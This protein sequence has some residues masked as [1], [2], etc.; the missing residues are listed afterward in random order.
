VIVK[1]LAHIVFYAVCGIVLLAA[2][3]LI[4]RQKTESEASARPVAAL[5]I[6]PESSGGAS[7]AQASR[8]QR[9]SAVNR[10]SA[11][12]NELILT[13][14]NM[15]LDEDEGDEQILTV[16]KTDRQGGF[17][18]IVV[19]DYV[20]QRRSWIRSWE[21]DTLCTK[22]STF[23]IQLKDLIGDHDN[24]IVCT[25]MA[26]SGMQTVN[27]FRR[28]PGSGLAFESIL[29][30]SAESI[31]IGETERNESYQLGQ[32]SGESWP[33]FAYRSNPGS[34]NVLDQIKERYSWN[35]KTKTY[36][37]TGEERITGA[38]ME[39][40]AVGRILT[41]SSAD[42]EEFLMG[43]WYESTNGPSGPLS[44]LIVFDKGSSSITF[45][46][47]TSQEVFRWTESH[48]TCY[49]LYIRCQ[50]ES[51]ED[52]YRL[53]D[54]ELR[55]SNIVSLRVFEDVQMKFDEQD[56]WDGVY[57]KLP[58]GSTVAT[59]GKTPSPSRALPSFKLDGPYRS[60]S[61]EVELT[62]SLP[63]YSYKTEQTQ[64]TGGYDL[65]LLG[66]VPVLELRPLRDD[67]MRSSRRVYKA[68][69][70][71]TNSGR[72]ILRRLVLSPAKAAIDGLELLQEDD[73]VLE[74]RVRG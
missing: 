26:E 6:E 69:F 3:Y 32:T 5:Q 70:T 38:Q 68:T 17:L 45:Y 58:K 44:R 10:I 72:D 61:G 41:G 67:G 60:A 63:R 12:P 36:V 52:L 50:N 4:L 19:A 57:T 66:G 30:L 21:A 64:E 14:R 29:A 34:A 7:T 48:A 39:R 25:G 62:F 35:P 20:P 51:V 22:I 8:S 28:V 40:D 16:R 33:V 27:I 9:E 24:V 47:S 1:K 59:A 15:N 31:A 11:L 56:R 53:M 37:K 43:I 23:S 71:E 65:Y 46:T 54:V 73:L 49:G 18:S 42:F 13:V 74:Q 2:G 55:G